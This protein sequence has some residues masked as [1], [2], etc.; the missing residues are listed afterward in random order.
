MASVERGDLIMINFDPTKGVEQAGHRPALV[1]SRKVF[2][3]ATGLT[4][5]CPITSQQK[6]YP[7]E[8]SLG[9]DL[10]IH[11]V[12]LTDQLKSLDLDS[13]TFDVRGSVPESIITEV[14]QKLNKIINE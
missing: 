1:I 14:Q 2:N 7:F 10:P 11:G 9:E 5:I 6:N 8:V 3:E 12:V 13:R 4:F